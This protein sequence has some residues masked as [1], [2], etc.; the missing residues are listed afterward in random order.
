MRKEDRLILEGI[1]LILD[2][3]E[4]TEDVAQKKMKENW[5]ERV[6]ELLQPD[7]KLK[8][9]APPISPK[10]LTHFLIVF[11]KHHKVALILLKKMIFLL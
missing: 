3:E 6:S 5:R 2:R 8:S 4:F 11:L 7:N 1:D 9:Y 10:N